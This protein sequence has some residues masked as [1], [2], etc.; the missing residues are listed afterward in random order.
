MIKVDN[1]GIPKPNTNKAMR[2]KLP[3]QQER[4][5]MQTYHEYYIRDV[6]E[7]DAFLNLHA[8]NKDFDWSA[9]LK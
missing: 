8:F 3:Y 2:E 4:I 5:M 7:I 9:Y 1:N 6:K